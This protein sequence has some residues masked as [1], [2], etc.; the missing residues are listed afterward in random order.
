M[1]GTRISYTTHFP[2]TDHSPPLPSPQ[3]TVQ[4][5]ARC[6]VRC[7]LLTCGHTVAAAAGV[8]SGACGA[9]AISRPV[10]RYHGYVTWCDPATCAVHE[11]WSD[12]WA[13]HCIMKVK[14]A[15]PSADH[16]APQSGQSTL[17]LT[18]RA[19]S[20]ELPIPSTMG[21]SPCTGTD[22]EFQHCFYIAMHCNVRLIFFKKY[23]VFI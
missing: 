8:G 23:R 16:T 20:C 19:E 17:H 14:V 4:M 22:V 9:P 7:L 11:W 5:A 1:C 10:S 12:G 18:P 2:T 3:Y 15:L 21:P 6:P 13:G